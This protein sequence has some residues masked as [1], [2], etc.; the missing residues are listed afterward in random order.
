MV[1]LILIH[2]KLG[3]YLLDKNSG[4][5]IYICIYI[6]IYI[7]IYILFGSAEEVFVLTE[8]FLKD[9]PELFTLLNLRRFVI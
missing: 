2:W 7:Y 8:S 3:S 1:S 9:C 5:G 6:Y 4:P